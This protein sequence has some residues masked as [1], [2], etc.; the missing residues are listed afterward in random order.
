MTSIILPILHTSSLI[1]TGSLFKCQALIVKSMQ[2]DIKGGITFGTTVCSEWLSDFTVHDLPF[3][4]SKKKEKQKYHVSS[5]LGTVILLN[6][7]LFQR[8]NDITSLWFE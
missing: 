7:Y 4:S 2:V 8:V 3:P 1:S 6:D 5:W